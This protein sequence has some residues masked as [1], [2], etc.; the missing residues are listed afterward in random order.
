MPG[1]HSSA[2][3]W[4]PQ[5]QVRCSSTPASAQMELVVPAKPDERGISSTSTV[6]RRVLVGMQE[7]DLQKEKD[8]SGC[9]DQYALP[10][11]LK[12]SSSVSTGK[13]S[14][15]YMSKPKISAT[16]NYFPRNRT[17]RNIRNNFPEAKV[18]RKIR[19]DQVL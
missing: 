3:V 14:Q 13:Y 11:R 15:K 8:D 6:L 16:K 12:N 2:V 1:V 5:P 17:R 7:W 4:Q 19:V 10:R 18:H 9:N